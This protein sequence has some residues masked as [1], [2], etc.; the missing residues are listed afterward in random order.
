M[1]REF[2]FR[3]WDKQEKVMSTPFTFGEGCGYKDGRDGTLHYP[4]SMDDEHCD[5]MQYTGIK[6]KNGVEVYED[7]IVKSYGQYIRRIKWRNGQGLS[8]FNVSAGNGLE[9][10]GNIYENPDLLK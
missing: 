5:F 10:I 4:E 1:K 9:V 7:D 2:K 6:D 3:L 8:G